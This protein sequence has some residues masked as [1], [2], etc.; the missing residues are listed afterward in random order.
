VS[1]PEERA[2]LAMAAD[3]SAIGGA[4]RD[5][6]DELRNGAGTAATARAIA[7]Y[8]RRARIAHDRLGAKLAAT[9]AAAAQPSLFVGDGR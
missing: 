7:E 8:L 9:E 4:V 3:A 1:R 6:L 5:I 2:L